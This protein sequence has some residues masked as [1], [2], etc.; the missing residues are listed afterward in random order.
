[1]KA[2]RRR[3]RE[4]RKTSGLVREH[5]ANDP[6]ATVRRVREPVLILNGERD[7]LVLPY[8]A[9][10]LAQ[11]LAGAG[12]KR[13]TLRIFPNLTHLFTPSGLD[14]SVTAEKSGIVS[15]EVLQTLQTWMSEV[16]DKKPK[17]AEA[18]VR[19][20]KASQK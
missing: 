14:P 1:M 8:H 19:E 5:A 13:V 3:T 17:Q 12:N 4:A 6:S 10:E 9:V 20:D 11:S 16:F 15:A 2:N 18:E 7:A